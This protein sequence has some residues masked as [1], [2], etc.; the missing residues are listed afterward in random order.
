[1]SK[2]NKS[3]IVDIHN[4]KPFTNTLVVAEN[5]GL[6]HKNVIALVRN[7]IE[8][9]QEFNPVAFQTRLGEKLPQGGYG[10]ATEFAE[11]S[12][13]QATYLI[14][15]FR[16]TPIV[17]Q[18]KIK[19]VK[20]FRRA[21]KEIERLRNQAKDT[22]WKFVRDESK[23][24]YKWMSE[25]LKDMRELMGKKT[26]FFHY[27]NEAKM[28]NAIMT[29]KCEGLSRDALSAQDLKA[30][31]D[32]QRLNSRLIAQGLDFATRKKMLKEH[33]TLKLESKAA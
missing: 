22:D 2:S 12:E 31:G 18:F 4:N 26:Q 14:T 8:D 32:L 6:Q 16:N 30:L 3:N 25:N 28:V 5:C 19:L 15:L 10:S 7:N 21:I 20:E 1:M 33:V 13:D 23:L 29:D 11:L 24:G 9:F 27:A 17:R